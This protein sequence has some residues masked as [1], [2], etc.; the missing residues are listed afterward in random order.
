SALIST[1][2]PLLFFWTAALGAWVLLQRQQSWLAA[3][4]L[5]LSIGLGLLSK[6]AMIYFVLCAAIWMILDQ[7][8]RWLLR[9]RKLA[10]V[11]AIAGA[12]VAPNILW[13]IENGLVTFAHTADNANWTGNLLRPGKALEFLGA[14][15]GVFGPILFGA[16]LS[17]TW[18]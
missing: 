15:F 17:V 16:L 14:Q 12:V 11:L 5:G 6:Y 13:N 4:L 7:P 2:V 1:D 3:S 18:F 8:S 9:D 10:L